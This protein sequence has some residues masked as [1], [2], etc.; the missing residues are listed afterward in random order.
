[1]AS[2]IEHVNRAIA[3]SAVTVAPLDSTGVDPSPVSDITS[4][5]WHLLARTIRAMAP[6][7]NLPVMPFMVVGST[8][9]KYWGRHSDRVFRFVPVPLG[10]GDR[11]RAHGVN[12]RVAV[13]DLATS[14]AFFAR[15]IR[16]V[17][18]L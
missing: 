15:L 5:A 10:K 17:E 1:M 7:E 13:A 9:A 18:G 14:V 12:E 11:E 6:G 2:V 3:D 8:D 4:D 16:G